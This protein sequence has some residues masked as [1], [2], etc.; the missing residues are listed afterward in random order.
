MRLAVRTT[1]W[2]FYLLLLLRVASG[3]TANLAFLLLPLY[4][5]RSRSHAIEA[6]FLSF[7][8]TNL[9]TALFPDPTTGNIARYLVVIAAGV[10]VFGRDLAVGAT[11]RLDKVFLPVV[12]FSAF[13]LVHSVFFS[14]VPVISVLKVLVW[15]L[16]F[17]TL[18]QAWRKITP[19][20]RT[21]LAD[22]IYFS[23]AVIVAASILATPMSGA[24]LPR[25]SLLRGVLNHSQALGSVA[26]VVA[27]WALMRVLQRTR[28]SWTD[29]AML[30]LSIL[31]VL[32]S[33]TRTALISFTIT[34]ILIGLMATVK[35]GKISLRS[36]PGVRSGRFSIFV[37]LGLIML[38]AQVNVVREVLLK[39]LS[40]D[41]SQTIAITDL[42]V[43]S[44]G[45]LIAEMWAN[46]ANDPLVGI[47]F[48]IASNPQEMQITYSAGIPV[49]AVIEKGV[50]FIQV[51]EEL[52]LVGIVAFLAMILAFLRR[53]ILI[54]PDRTAVLFVILLINMGEASLLSAGGIGL[55]Q[56]VLIGWTLSD[57]GHS[58]ER[59]RFQVRFPEVKT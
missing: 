16:A 9:N 44:R 34:I 41:Q 8:F 27:V 11:L 19:E 20:A 53:S 7:I 4:A 22:R 10:S 57:E 38:L 39:G 36:I 35:F 49:G 26:A 40:A 51:W 37:V 23:L 24:H 48:G 46:I 6:L 56:L 58:L 18:L 54:N 29:L 45:G 12:F 17:L 2:P 21:K 50:T 43:Q 28:P 52:G 15:G 42:Y 55:V 14:L 59:V 31:A 33:G 3:P 1:N 5:L 13:A 32:N 30:S 25:S 47:G